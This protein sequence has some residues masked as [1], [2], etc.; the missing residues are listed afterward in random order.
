MN[1]SR[2][3]Q[4]V[5]ALLHK[6]GWH[7]LNVGRILRAQSRFKVAFILC[8]AISFEV[9]LWLL[10]RHGFQLL[11]HLGGV[12]TIIISRLF[13]L[14]FLG[15]GLMLVFSGT[16]TSYSTMF[17]SQEIPF[18]LVRPYH[19][20]QIV[21]YKFL[22][23]AALSSW[24]FF[25]II[26]PFV[27]AYAVHEKLSVL[28]ALWTFM[29]SVP[30]LLLF[31]GI[32]VLIAMVFVRW[33]PPEKWMKPI[34]IAAGLAVVALLWNP[35][36]EVV[37]APVDM[38]LNLSSLLPGLRLSSNRMLP[39]WW[40]AEGIL[41]LSE[42]EWVRG[43]MLWGIIMANA[44]LVGMCVEALGSWTFFEGW[45]R[46]QGSRGHRVV[47]SPIID[48]IGTLLCVFPSDVRALLIKD[49]KTFFRDPVQWS[50]ALI[51]FGLLGFYFANLRTFRYHSLPESWRNII[52]FLNVFSVSAVMCS[53]G[54]RFVFPQLSLEGQGF[55][56]LGLSPTSMS[57]VLLTKFILALA[58]MTTVSVCLMLLSTGMLAATPATRIAAISVAFAISF[59]VCGLSVGLGAV[60]LDLDQRNPAAIV[61]GFGGTLNLVLSLAFMLGSILPFGIL[62]HLH[63]VKG[64]P[65]DYLAGGFAAAGAWLVVIT[66]CATIIPLWFG[67]RALQRQEF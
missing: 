37:S 47:A 16:V 10:F 41:A 2:Q 40:I 64:Y 57:T 34:M 19:V 8:F 44:L 29:F 36:R 4:P 11:S 22:E 33:A 24:A 23:S 48:R 55:W 32:G 13:S 1:D 66:L 52:A 39:G 58:G 27:G 65:L 31:S 49:I 14:F 20:R 54:S 30:Y 28:L 56:I 60:F 9:G 43:S 67:H 63:F 38:R 46:V 50:Q 25:F 62:F 3:I 53:L 5:R 12:G 17:R 51:F 45:Q 7:W 15:M 59:A 21:L 26:I 42:G 18:L 35:F 61:S 6:A